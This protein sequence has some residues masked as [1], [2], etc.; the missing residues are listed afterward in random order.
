ML[1]LGELV[2]NRDPAWGFRA[3]AVHTD[4][5][6]LY[7]HFGV[8]G[9]PVSEWYGIGGSGTPLKS[10]EGSWYS[11]SESTQPQRARE[12]SLSM[13]ILEPPSFSLAPP[14]ATDATVFT[15]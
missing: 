2:G 14:H 10:A 12:V 11:E 5:H 3:G 7:H 9:Q 4:D 1:R 15:L 8:W 6:C 13:S